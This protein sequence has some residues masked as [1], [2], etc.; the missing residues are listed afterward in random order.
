MSTSSATNQQ[1]SHPRLVLPPDLRTS[2][3]LQATL[4]AGSE[5]DTME[6]PQLS[7]SGCPACTIT[8]WD[9]I[10]GAAPVQVG[11]A[12]LSGTASQPKP[13]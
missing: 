2:L 3:T 13:R 9:S 1:C 8:F 12:T 4:Q 7:A 6:S 5:Y 11:T 10:A